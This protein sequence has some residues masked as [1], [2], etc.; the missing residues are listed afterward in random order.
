MSEGLGNA[1]Q[2][3]PATANS[4]SNSANTPGGDAGTSRTDQKQPDLKPNF[5]GT[6]HKVKIDGRESEVDYDELVSDY[7]ARK[8]SMQRFNEAQR[9]MKEAQEQASTAA[10]L[11]EIRDALKSKDHNALERL[12]GPELAEEIA[13]SFLIDKMEK[14]NM[15]P[16][17]R[18]AWELE[19]ENK[20]LKK[21]QEDDEKSAKQK[22]KEDAD[23]KAHAQLDNEIKDALQ[24]LGR[25]PTPTMA[26]RIVDEMIIAREG[27]KGE[28]SAKDASVRAIKRIHGDIKEYLPGLSAEELRQVI[29]QE[30]IDALR[31]DEVKRVTGEKS[32]QRRRAPD[33]TRTKTADKPKSIDEWFDYKS[34]KLTRR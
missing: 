13:E 17:E 7:Q 30:V 29:P 15:T 9:L 27:K 31:E 26:L 5:K 32:Q 3:T 25:K 14:K 1:G 4:A 20:Q 22:A 2:T 33:S 16:A 18:R 19:Q 10:E 6:K 23:R 11:K 28:I 21:K 24:G 34:K 8:S 12:L